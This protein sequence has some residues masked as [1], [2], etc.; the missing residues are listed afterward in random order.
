MAKTLTD[1]MDV[2]VKETKGLDIDRDNSCGFFIS[3][4]FKENQFY[5]WNAGSPNE[6]A[7]ALLSL[8]DQN[9]LYKHIIK[10]VAVELN[11]SDPNVN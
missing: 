10:M 5:V 2:L 3:S 8:C 1:L 6:L 9:E 7:N 11:N 4:N